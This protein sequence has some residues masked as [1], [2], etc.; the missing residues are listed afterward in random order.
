MK[1]QKNQY[2][3]DGYRQGYWEKTYAC[4]QVIHQ[5]NFVHGKEEGLWRYFWKNG[6]LAEKIYYKNGTPIDYYKNC[7]PDGTI[8]MEQILIR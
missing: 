2:D 4:G 7:N 1:T 6:N 3:K 8:R 5:G